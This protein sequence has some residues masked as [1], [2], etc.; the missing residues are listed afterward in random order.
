MTES[1]LTRCS[2]CGKGVLLAGR[3]K[4]QDICPRCWLGTGCP[5]PDALGPVHEIE[6]QTRKRMQRRGGDHANL[7]RKGLT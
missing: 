2:V 7:V 3:V 1:W 6:E 5:L 4:G